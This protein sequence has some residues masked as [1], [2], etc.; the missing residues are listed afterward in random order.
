MPLYIQSK[1]LLSYQVLFVAL[2]LLLGLTCLGVVSLQQLFGYN[3][4]TIG[5]DAENEAL[6]ATLGFMGVL[7]LSI[8]FMM[9]YLMRE[10]RITSSDRRQVSAP[11]S[12]NERRIRTERRA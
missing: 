2:F 3:L 1:S 11:V 6:L 8:A 5:A 9:I 12:F 4:V 10:K 7:G